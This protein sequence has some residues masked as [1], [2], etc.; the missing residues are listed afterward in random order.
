VWVE[1]RSNG[2]QGSRFVIELPTEAP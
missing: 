1:D 2:E